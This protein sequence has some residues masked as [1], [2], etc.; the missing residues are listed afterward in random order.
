[1][2]KSIIES[3]NSVVIPAA[4]CIKTAKGEDFKPAA[5][6][7]FSIDWK[8]LTATTK[9]FSFDMAKTNRAKITA[10]LCG[11]WFARELTKLNEAR[12]YYAEINWDE[13]AEGENAAEV[14]RAKAIAAEAIEHIEAAREIIEARAKESGSVTV[15]A[16]ISALRREDIPA[17]MVPAAEALRAKAKEIAEAVAKVITAAEAEAARAVLANPSEAEADSA[18]LHAAAEAEALLKAYEISESKDSEGV[19]NLYPI[20]AAATKLIKAFWREAVAEGVEKANYEA[21]HALTVKLFGMLRKPRE[22]NR[23]GKVTEALATKEDLARE[24]V[25]AIVE[26]AQK[27]AAREAAEAEAKRAAA[28]KPA[29]K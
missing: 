16:I 9:A 7:L 20:R 8:T 12:A 21:S 29:N 22:V 14:E 4:D 27:R 11:E 17:A 15:K 6:S 10:A 2:K 28:A 23:K 1:M 13:A 18:K 24:V 25:L 26:A 3:I 5:D 19:P